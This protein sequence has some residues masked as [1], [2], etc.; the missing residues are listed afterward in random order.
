MQLRQVKDIQY[1]LLPGAEREDSLRYG[2]SF[3]LRGLEHLDVEAVHGESLRARGMGRGG[4][5]RHPETSSAT[6]AAPP[7]KP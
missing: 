1:R 3:I 6:K 7:M 5:E 2:R 4:V